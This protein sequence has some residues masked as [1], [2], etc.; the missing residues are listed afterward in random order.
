MTS[1][2][3]LSPCED[4]LP[5]TRLWIMLA[6]CT[7]AVSAYIQRRLE[8]EK[9][10]LSDFAVLEVLLHKGPLTISAIGEKVLLA[11][12]S[13][14]S[15]VD[16]LDKRGLVR[17]KDSPSDRRVR[18]VELTPCGRKFI[19]DIFERHERDLEELM[20]PLSPEERRTLYTSLRKLGLH[21]RSV[22]D[23]SQIVTISATRKDP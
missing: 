19:S 6:R 17:R 15:A 23:A 12:P 14:T 11:N 3:Q 5:A 21:A 16:R 7:N 1:S 2:P 9:L 20:Q 4:S 10:G 18:I 8:Q 22:N 13:M